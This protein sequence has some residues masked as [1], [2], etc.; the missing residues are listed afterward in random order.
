MT[1]KKPTSTLGLFND[2]LVAFFED[3]AA[4]YPEERDIKMALEAIQGAK[5]INPKLVLDLFINNVAKPLHDD[6]LA[7]DDVKVFSYAKGVINTKYNEILSALMIFDRH[8]PTMSD[9][10]RKAIWNYLKVLV[11]LSDKAR[12]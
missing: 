10:N 6:I 4:T 11:I 2:K 8:W 3:L 7:E 5:K 1:T 9:S 12:A